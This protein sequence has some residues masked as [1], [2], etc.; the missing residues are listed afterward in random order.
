MFNSRLLSEKYF[1][2]EGFKKDL[3][4]FGGNFLKICCKVII[5]RHSFFHLPFHEFYYWYHSHSD[6]KH[7]VF[8]D[9]QVK[10]LTIWNIQN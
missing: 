5:I 10:I 1:V 7:Q 9:N 4:F 6:S 2:R 3:L 8:I